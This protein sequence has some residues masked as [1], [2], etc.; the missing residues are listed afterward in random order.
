MQIA[1][2]TLGNMR[3]NGVRSLY[4]Y[5]IACHHEAIFNV[6][7]YADDITVPSFVARMRC[8]HCNERKADVRPNWNERRAV[9]QITRPVGSRHGS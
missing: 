3:A 4:V 7:S 6:D 9:G 2:M 1:A 5:C 8:Q